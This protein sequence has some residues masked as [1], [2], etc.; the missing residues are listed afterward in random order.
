M[1]RL[2]LG[3]VLG[4]MAAWSGDLLAQDKAVVAEEG[5]VSLF[6]GKSL[7]GWT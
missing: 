7:A 2:T 5:F 3:F 1:N 4:L 6:D